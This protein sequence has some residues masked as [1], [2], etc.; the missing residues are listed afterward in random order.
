MDLSSLYPSIILAYNIDSSTQLGKLLL[1]NDEGE[2]IGYKFMDSLS[3]KDYVNIGIE[4]FNL[5][6]VKELIDSINKE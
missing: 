3:S 6:T 4:W 2:D 5:P 1:Y